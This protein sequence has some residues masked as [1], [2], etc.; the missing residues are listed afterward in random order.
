MNQLFKKSLFEFED[1]SSIESFSGTN[2]WLSNFWP[3]EVYLDELKF[4]SVEA[5]YVAA[6]TTD[7]DVRKYVQSLDSSGKCKAFGKTMTIRSD[8]KKVKLSV[9]E[10]L[11]RQKFSQGTELAEKLLET[12]PKELI[13]CNTW[14]DT[15]WGVCNNVGKNHLGKLLMKIRRELRVKGAKNV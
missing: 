3:C 14:N 5:G 4:R 1:I 12:Y 13:E 15:F 10:N 7:I 11:L 8:W 9:M 2:R 6:K